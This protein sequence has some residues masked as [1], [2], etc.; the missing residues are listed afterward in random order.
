M[1]GRE[2]WEGDI[3]FW[4]RTHFRDL[5]FVGE[6][7]CEDCAAAEEVLDF[8]GVDVGVVGGFVVVEHEV[9]CV[10]LE[11][12][13]EELEDCVV[14]GAVVPEYVCIGRGHKPLDGFQRGLK[15]ETDRDSGSS[16]L[17]CIVLAI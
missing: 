10:G 17:S 12:E 13:E 9:D 2:G 1:E 3:G 7:D 4:G 11:A 6:E 16:I 5:V 8:E 15:G 14:E